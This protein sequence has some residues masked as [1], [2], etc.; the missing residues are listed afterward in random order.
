MYQV[1]VLVEYCKGCGLCV[2]ACPVEALEFSEQLSVLAV[3]PARPNP[4]VECTG[5]LSCA[6]M[7]PDA[8][9]EVVEVE[10]GDEAHAEK[11]TG[12]ADRERR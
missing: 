4:D 9:I 7:C 3:Y 5:C 1:R 8:A 11:A 6:L 2:E 10:V 12:S